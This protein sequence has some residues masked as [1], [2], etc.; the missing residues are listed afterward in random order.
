[1]H[2]V[3]LTRGKVQLLSSE[4]KIKIHT[5]ANCVLVH[6]GKCHERAATNG[7]RLLCIAHLIQTEGYAAISDWLDDMSA[8]MDVSVERNLL[9]SVLTEMM[10]NSQGGSLCYPMQKS[11]N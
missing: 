7:G 6:T 4:L 3:L 11:N 8:F 9:E 2:E 5:A 10:Q 1:M